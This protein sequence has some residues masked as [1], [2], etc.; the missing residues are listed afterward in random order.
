MPSRWLRAD[1]RGASPYVPGEQPRPDERIVKLNTN[2]NPYPP[3]AA[4]VEA[5]RA[6]AARLRRYPDPRSTALRA[7][8]ARVYGVGQGS[9]LAANGSD[10]A[11]RMLFQAFVAAG[12]AVAYPVP[13]YS[14]YPVLTRA[15]GAR[16]VEIPWHPDYR[17]PAD[18]LAAAG[19]KMILLTNPNAPSGTLVPVAEVEALAARVEALVVVDEAYVEFAP[20]GSSC[21]PNVSPRGRRPNLVVVRTLS[22]AASLAG[23]RAGFALAA[24]ET[25]AD[26][27]LVR[28]SYNLDAV[29]QAA[30][31]AAFD[32]WDEIRAGCARVAAE[33]ERLAAA[34]RAEGFRVWPSASNFLLAE[35]PGLAG[36]RLCAELKRRGILIRCFP[37]PPG[38]VRITV[39]TPEETDILLG[40]I[41]EVTK[42]A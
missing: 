8:A 38:P 39:G 35:R 19:A 7:A 41:R 18:A 6:A 15:A 37:N 1:L 20:E 11:L 9:V 5:A 3:P 16:A 34:L 27:D 12:E 13:S 33:R 26:L 25:I 31:E 2:E 17:L 29:A 23:L 40:G 28:D 22:K 4:V 21:A 42:G 36:E 30:A 14:L 32:A 10:E 24:P